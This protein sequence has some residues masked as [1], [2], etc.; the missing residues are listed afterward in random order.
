MATFLSVMVTPLILVL[1]ILGLNRV[2]R[3]K[4]NKLNNHQRKA[5]LMAHVIFVITY[6]S[7]MLGVLLLAF[8]ARQTDDGSLIYA[9]HLFIQ[10]FD[11]FFIIPGGLGA[12]VTGIWLAVRTNWGFAKHYWVIAKWAANIM[13]ITFGANYMRICIHDNF[14]IMFSENAHP[15]QNHLYL[16]NQQMLFAGIAISFAFLIFLLVISYFKPW[17]KRT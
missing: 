6:F 2:G 8:S 12:V 16:A 10:Y 9:A 1:L 5:W 7:G 11:W 14:N 13:A 15:L 4:P 17:G 3:R